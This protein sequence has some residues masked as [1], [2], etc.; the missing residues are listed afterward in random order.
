MSGGCRETAQQRCCTRCSPQPLMNITCPGREQQCSSRNTFRKIK[1]LSAL[2]VRRG[3]IFSL[4]TGS[5][6]I[7]PHIKT[8]TLMEPKKLKK[9][10]LRTCWSESSSDLCAREKR[11]HVSAAL[12]MRETMVF[13]S[14]SSSRHL[15]PDPLNESLQ[16]SNCQFQ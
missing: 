3:F 8:R 2:S 4:Q 12:E 11:V 16:Y 14:T 15:S 1:T 13:W 5:V 10:M 9:R 7:I 6:V